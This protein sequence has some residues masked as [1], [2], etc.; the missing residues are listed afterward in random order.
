M[1]VADDLKDISENAA[2]KNWPFEYRHINSPNEMT[3]PWDRCPLLHPLSSSLAPS[4]RQLRSF[5]A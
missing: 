3:V 1:T 2:S 5:S 4:W